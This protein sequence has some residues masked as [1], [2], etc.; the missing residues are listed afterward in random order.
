MRPSNGLGERAG[1][2]ALE[3]ITMALVTRREH[4]GVDIGIDTRQIYRTSR[5]VQNLTGF[6]PPPNKAIIGDNAFAHE[7]GI[8]QHGVLN[9]SLTYE[10]MSPESV[11]IQNNSIVLGKHSGRHAFE[12]RLR[13]LGHELS[14]VQIN[15]MFVRFKDLADRKK[16]CST[17]I[18]KLWWVINPSRCL[19][20]ISSQSIMWSAEPKARPWLGPTRHSR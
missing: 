17:G 15:E 4:F 14:T 13:S 16:P 6:L 8:H 20:I 11:G 18:L 10:I 2:A 1:N 5:I 3:E 19:N 9:N 7:S 12:E